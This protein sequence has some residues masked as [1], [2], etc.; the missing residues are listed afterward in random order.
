MENSI[1]FSTKK[2][3]GLAEDYTAFDHDIV[4]HI[5]S[6]FADLQQIGIGPEEGY[7]IDDQGTEEWTEYITTNVPPMLL[8]SVRSYVF[9][10]VKML[11]DPG[12]FTG[13]MKEAAEAQINK[14][15]WRL[16]TARE[17]MLHPLSEFVEEEV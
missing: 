10:R 9:L 8:N 2:I 7:A 15:E 1:L 13:A 14:F 12:S 17:A 4:V 16:N 3:L 6:V 11:F 5:N